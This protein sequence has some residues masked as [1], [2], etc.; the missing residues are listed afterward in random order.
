MLHLQDAMSGLE[1][2][3]HEFDEDFQIFRVEVKHRFD[4]IDGRLGE[5]ATRAE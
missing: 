5:V 1:S 4:R 3:F 2:R